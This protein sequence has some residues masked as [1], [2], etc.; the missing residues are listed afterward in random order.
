MRRRSRILVSVSLAGFLSLAG[1]VGAVG[2][3]RP[4][5]LERYDRVCDLLFSKDETYPREYT[6]ILRYAPSFSGE[7]QIQISKVADGYRVVHTHLP[8]GDPPIGE[9]MTTFSQRTGNYQAE[10]IAAQIRVNREVFVVA[11][12]VLDAVLSDLQKLTM[13]LP[14]S[15]IVVDG[16]HYNLW[17]ENTGGTFRMH[18]SFVD[19]NFGSKRFL[20]PVGEWMNRVKELV[21]KQKAGNAYPAHGK[22]R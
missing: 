12:K 14:E 18:Y 7:S 3:E 5:V 2:Q 15:T 19:V 6:I 8:K 4:T 20:H 13:S 21:Q 16:T 22:G 9:Q 17:F 1:F 10:G 11:A